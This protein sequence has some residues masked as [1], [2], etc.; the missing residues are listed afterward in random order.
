MSHCHWL[1]KGGDHRKRKAFLKC[2]FRLYSESLEK[3]SQ[4]KNK[5]MKTL[6]FLISILVL[7]AGFVYVSAAYNQATPVIAGQSEEDDNETDLLLAAGEAEDNETLVYLT[8][9]GEEDNETIMQLAEDA[10]EGDNETEQL[11]A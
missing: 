8:A 4:E 6:G 7:V 2:T 1:A 3:H 5:T 11:L 10:G 9:E